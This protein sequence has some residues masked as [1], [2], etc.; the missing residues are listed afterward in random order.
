MLDGFANS[1]HIRP[2]QGTDQGRVVYR[3][4]TLFMF[5]SVDSEVE[6]GHEE[7]TFNRLSA[8]DGPDRQRSLAQVSSPSRP[9]FT[10]P[11]RDR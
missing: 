2:A 7:E 5:P 11:T 3:L 10:S 9:S 4:L 6:G 1:A 8:I